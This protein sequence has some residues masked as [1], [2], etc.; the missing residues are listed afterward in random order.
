MGSHLLLGRRAAVPATAS[1]HQIQQASPTAPWHL[2][3]P[4][5]EMK[6]NSFAPRLAPLTSQQLCLHLDRHNPSDPTG[7]P[8]PP[9]C[10]LSQ[11][12]VLFWGH[13]RKDRHSNTLLIPNTHCLVHPA[14][15]HAGASWSRVFL[16][17]E[18]PQSA[19]VCHSFPQ[20]GSAGLGVRRRLSLLSVYGGWKPSWERTSVQ[21]SQVTIK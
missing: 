1:S 20:M 21:C 14:S 6:W 18:S 13:G 16:A 11:H 5:P 15:R 12:E 19:P 17:Q 9:N 2:S 4:G 10:C 8:G 3:E 7:S